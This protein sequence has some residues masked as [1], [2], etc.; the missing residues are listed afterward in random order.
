MMEFVDE[1]PAKIVLAATPGDSIRR[2]SRKIGGTYS[3]VH[4]WVTRLEEAGFLARDDGVQITNYE[5]REQYD[6]LMAAIARNSPPSIEEAYVLP[7]FAGLPFAYARIDAVYVWTHGGYQVA[8]G[9]DDYPVFVQV[10]DHQLEQ[11]RAFFDRYGVPTAVGER[12]NPD[13]RDAA[14]HYVL[15]PMA[16]GLEREWVDGN[17]V[18]PLE[19]TIA[20]MREYRVNYEPAMEM[21]ADEYEIDIDAAHDDPRLRA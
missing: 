6:R 5:V 3:W 12:A 15:F 17:P 19:E 2:I 1:T 8:R 4:T 16:D 13:E 11:W 7:H 18:V 10:N 20:H 14:V 21:I 9:H